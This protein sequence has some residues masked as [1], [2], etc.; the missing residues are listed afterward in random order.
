M[1]FRIVSDIHL[2]LRNDEYEDDEYE[3]VDKLNYSTFITPSKDDVC[4]LLGDIGNPRTPRYTEFIVWCVKHFKDVIV[5]PGNHE[6]WYSNIEETNNQLV[7]ICKQKG[8]Y[9]ANNTTFIYEG[10]VCICSTLWSY[11]P[12]EAHFS[13][14][15]SMGDYKYIHNF[16]IELNN[17]LHLESV[18]YITAQVKKYSSTH[19]VLVCTHHSPYIY[20]TSNPI[21]ENV[22]NRH[23]NYCFSTDLSHLFKD[24]N[25]WCYGH[26]HYNNSFMCESTNIIS[27]QVGY[28]QI[29]LNGHD[30]DLIAM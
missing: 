2:E 3:D 12:Q 6:Y 7:D 20:G 18:K 11:I 21:Y 28:D 9:F 24:V 29:N 4:I 15:N 19:K 22:K 17:Q 30:P 10:V 8:A 14:Y 26:T 16:D 23:L 13:V 25:V 1:H 5:V 27:N